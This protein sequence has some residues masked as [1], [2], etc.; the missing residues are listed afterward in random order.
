[1]K[2][3]I[4]TGGKAPF[5][6]LV[7]DEKGAPIQSVQSVDVHLR[8]G[9]L[10][11]AQVTLIGDFLDIQV[12]SEDTQVFV[13]F[14]QSYV[15]QGDILLAEGDRYVLLREDFIK[16]LTTAYEQYNEKNTFGTHA[17][18][19]H[20]LELLTSGHHKHVGRQRKNVTTTVPRSDK[21]AG[22]AA[23]SESS[24]APTSPG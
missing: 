3:R 7:T 21:Q 11:T 12:D 2:L 17:E 19:T 23:R 1:M 9:E 4:T 6:G 15:L 8:A 10:P 14:A 18:L 24:S 5:D 22:D 13:T 20:L 16:K